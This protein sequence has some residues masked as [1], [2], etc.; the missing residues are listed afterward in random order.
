MTELCVIQPRRARPGSRTRRR[1]TQARCFAHSP[2]RTPP[3]AITHHRSPSPLG[4]WLGSEGC[5]SSLCP[6]HL[7]TPQVCGS[8]HAQ[9]SWEVLSLP[10]RTHNLGQTSGWLRCHRWQHAV[11]TPSLPRSRP[12]TPFTWDQQPKGWSVCCVALALICLIIPRDSPGTQDRH[13]LRGGAQP[14]AGHNSQ[15]RR[16]KAE[17]GPQPGTR[18]SVLASSQAEWHPH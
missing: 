2:T 9:Q 4:G 1:L 3:C 16:P 12:P 5:T 11:P 17:G 14:S 13:P 10:F 6:P 15:V 7:R 18:G 8:G